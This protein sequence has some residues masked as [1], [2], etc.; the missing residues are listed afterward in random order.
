VNGL[1][2]LTLSKPFPDKCGW[3]EA[4]DREQEWHINQASHYITKMEE[5]RSLGLYAL[6]HALI[7]FPY[8]VPLL[9][10][11]IYSITYI[12]YAVIDPHCMEKALNRARAE[13][14]R[15]GIE[16]LTKRLPEVLEVPPEPEIHIYADYHQRMKHVLENQS[17]CN[18]VL[19]I[20][21]AGV[22]KTTIATSYPENI[23]VIDHLDEWS[24]GRLEARLAQI[25]NQPVIGCCRR[26][27]PLESILDRH[28]TTIKVTEPDRANTLEI[29]K[30]AFPRATEAHLRIAVSDAR[31]TFP[32]S[33][34]RLYDEAPN[35]EQVA[36]FARQKY[37][38]P[39]FSEEKIQGLEAYLKDRIKGQ[40][41]AIQEIL[42]SLRNFARGK[43]T[44]TGLHFAGL[45]GTGK[46]EMAHVIAEWLYGS[47][48]KVLQID[49]GR[50]QHTHAEWT[51]LGSP[52]G[53]VGHEK[54]GIILERAKEGA[55]LLLLDDI[56]Q[57]SAECISAIIQRLCDKGKLLDP[58]TGK[59]IDMPHV[60]VILT[61]NFGAA[62]IIDGMREG[63]EYLLFRKPT[64]DPANYSV[65]LEIT[66]RVERAFFMGCLETLNRFRTVPF[67]P[68][69]D[70]E[71]IDQVVEKFLNEEKT[72]H[73][74]EIEWIQEFVYW[75]T[76]TYGRNTEEG[77]RGIRYY[78]QNQL[79]DAITQT[80][81]AKIRLED[82][83]KI[84]VL[85]D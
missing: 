3:F 43:G 16:L 60:F 4:V 6:G 67:S 74:I 23:L 41:A 81:E 24:N 71:V 70:E 18:R 72:M 65:L 64:I 68:V 9:N 11:L 69:I 56:H 52:S 21:P 19:L 44:R 45:T 82:G 35:K 84:T 58:L 29:M 31:G 32:G 2:E 49:M 85:E 5:N 20:G 15:E 53:L 78:I 37:E 57:S 22:G 48:D 75:V 1:A 7:A 63:T 50:H 80:K 73:E 12:F 14:N 39:S 47:R 17:F 34:V 28:F 36:D 59:D 8:H 55:F 10:C 42:P 38:I 62:E 26:K 40:D 51:L 77:M 66:K 61:S 33:A 46:T 25:G 13:H 27:G 76:G 83:G 79:R 30:K 54:G